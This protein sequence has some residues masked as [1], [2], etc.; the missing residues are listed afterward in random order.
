MDEKTIKKIITQVIA[1]YNKEIMTDKKNSFI[2]ETKC[3]QEEPVP[4]ETSARH[5]HLSQ[6]D[7]DRLFGVGYTLTKKKEISQP[8]QYLCEERVRLIGPKGTIDR[9]AVLGPTREH[10]QIEISLTDNK[11][12]GIEAPIRISGDLENSAS[13]FVQANDKMVCACESVIVAQNHLHLSFE[14]AQS[15]NLKDGQKIKIKMDTIRPITFDDVIVRV[16]KKAKLSFHIDYDEGN[17]CGLVSGNLGYICREN[18]CSIHMTDRCVTNAQYYGSYVANELNPTF[19]EK[20][21]K[22]D[23]KLLTES[24]LYNALKED[25]NNILIDKKTII[26]PLAHDY[27]KNHNMKIRFI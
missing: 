23:G 15:Y 12:F 1:D 19:C 22:I 8:G 20:E 18:D 14:E 11:L 2:T 26:T 25:A 9:V 10:T 5:V 27:V 3:R 4:V 24:M 13:L 21:I 16:S 17:A 7:V 6:K